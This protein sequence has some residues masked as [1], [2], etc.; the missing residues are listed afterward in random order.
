MVANA[1]QSVVTVDVDLLVKSFS[2]YL[3]LR[4][5]EHRIRGSGVFQPD[6]GRNREEA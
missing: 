2:R 1:T 5:P 4:L 3:F 6:L